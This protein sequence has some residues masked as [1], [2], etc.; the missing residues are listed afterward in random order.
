MG[1]WKLD[2]SCLLGYQHPLLGAKSRS[3]AAK[4]RPGHS[5]YISRSSG[6]A[7]LW[8]CS[9]KSWVRLWKTSGGGEAVQVEWGGPEEQ[10]RAK[11]LC[12][13][14]RQSH[15]GFPPTP[16]TPCPWRISLPSI[17]EPIMSEVNPVSLQ[18]NLPKEDLDRQRQIADLFAD[19]LGPLVLEPPASND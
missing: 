1:T 5:D 2:W 6:R 19:S 7:G 8:E 3:G 10:M 13:G 16:P 9:H 12:S 4:E 15:L 11:E 14:K 18:R 17:W